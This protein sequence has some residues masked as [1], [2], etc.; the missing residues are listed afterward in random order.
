MT[1]YVNV[2]T[3][4]PKYALLISSLGVSKRVLMAP[5]GNT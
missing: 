1:E 4:Y 3:E 5:F 2:M